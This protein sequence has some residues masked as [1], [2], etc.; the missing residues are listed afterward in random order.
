MYAIWLMAFKLQ[1]EKLR[2]E[3]PKALKWIIFK[4]Q[5][6]QSS[7]EETHNGS[8]PLSACQ[9]GKQQQGTEVGLAHQHLSGP[10]EAYSMVIKLPPI[11]KASINI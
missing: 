11:T 5:C 10:S 8:N 6:R 1:G 9:S 4:E 3:T 7:A 2:R